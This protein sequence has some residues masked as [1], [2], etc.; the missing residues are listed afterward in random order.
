[1]LLTS[2]ARCGGSLVWKSPS[3]R[4]LPTCPG[5]GASSQLDRPEENSQAN[6]CC[7]PPPRRYRA[8]NNTSIATV[9]TAPT[10]SPRPTAPSGVPAVFRL[11]SLQDLIGTVQDWFTAVLLSQATKLL[12]PALTSH[13]A[14]SAIG[15]YMMGRG[16]LPAPAGRF[17]LPWRLWHSTGSSRG[18]GPDQGVPGR[19]EQSAGSPVQAQPFADLGAAGQRAGP[20]SRH[21]L[22]VGDKRVDR[23]ADHRAGLLDRV[24][25]VVA[26]SAGTA[27]GRRVAIVEIVRRDDLVEILRAAV[28][29]A[30][31]ELAHDLFRAQ[32]DAHRS[33]PLTAG[34]A[35]RSCAM[36]L[37]RVVMPVV[38]FSNRS[39]GG[40]AAGS[41]SSYSQVRPEL[42]DPPPAEPS[43]WRGGR[44]GRRTR[45]ARCGW[46][47]PASAWRT[48]S[49]LRPRRAA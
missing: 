12:V 2:S 43:D 35:D 21:H 16:W 25:V 30:V 1:M 3:N 49:R 27:P 5:T 15:W 42:G 26:R 29:V 39:C 34:T 4:R 11:M 48:P 41:S 36:M 46:K 14:C 24:L 31:E 9:P 13:F 47:E 28:G 45:T 7:L 22:P 20:D 40:R 38:P 18:R 23:V 37:G 10:A 33:F 17:R 8:Y 19:A 44:M 32:P 6:K